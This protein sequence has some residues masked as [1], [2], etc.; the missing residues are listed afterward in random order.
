MARIL[1]IK[2][3]ALGDLVQSFAPFAAIRRHH[4]GAHLALLTT[5]PFV[6]LCE[7]SPWFDEVLVDDRPPWWR[8]NRVLALRRMLRGYDFVYDLQTSGRSS[9]YFRLAGRPGWSGI[10]RGASHPHDNC[11]R[12]SMHTRERQAD[13]LARAGIA[14]VPWPDLG[15]LAG[16]GRSLPEPYALLVPGAAPHRPAKRWPVGRYAAL[17][18]ALAARGLRPVVVGAAGDAPLAAAIRS[19]C[20]TALDLT[21]QTGLSEL[22][23]VASRARVAI[24]NDTG[25]MHLAAAMG[26]RCVVLFSAESDPA[27]T[28]PRGPDPERVVVLRRDDLAD[29]QVEDVLARV[30]AFPG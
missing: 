2:L 3:G 11:A 22:G 23:G 5:R 1:I 9:R 29:L 4:P 19:A 27:L 30:A 14:E 26:T 6:A 16:H 8:L 18:S 17:A 7:A 12:N 15:W 24:G 13:Q 21:G 25:P 28:A 20:P 10:A